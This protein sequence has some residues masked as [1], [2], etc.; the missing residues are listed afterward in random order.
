MAF[1]KWDVVFVSYPNQEDSSKFTKRPAII[2]DVIGDTAVICPVTKQLHQK[3]RYSKFIEVDVS[4]EENKTL[5]LNFSS[6]IVLD[7]QESIDKKRIEFS[8]GKC[9]GTIVKQIEELIKKP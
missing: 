6:L 5:K 7:R 9:N 1:N 4:S 3:S 8:F 2:L